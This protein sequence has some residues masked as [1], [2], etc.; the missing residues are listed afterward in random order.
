MIAEMSSRVFVQ[1]STDDDRKE[2]FREAVEAQGE[3]MS[4]FLVACMDAAILA[5]RDGR[6]VLLPVQFTTKP[7]PAKPRA[8]KA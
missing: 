2:E 5:R 1:V 8:R 3:T 7:L 6:K 4:G